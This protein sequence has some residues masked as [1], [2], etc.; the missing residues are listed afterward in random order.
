MRGVIL[1]SPGDVR[2][3]ERDRPSI[4][5][6][7]DA[8]IHIAATCV[9]GSDLWPY[10]GIEPVDGPTPMGHEYLGVVEETGSDVRTVQVGDFVVGSFFASDN[11]CAITGRVVGVNTAIASL[12]GGSIGIGFAIPIDRAADTA[13]RIIA[14][15]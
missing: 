10:R 7:T 2:V 9:C 1:H 4:V 3:E 11:T 6:P 13:E 12:G 15:S 14:G 5:E 8:T